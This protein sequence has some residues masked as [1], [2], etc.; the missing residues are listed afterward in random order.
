M[1]ESFKPLLE[2]KDSILFT[3]VGNRLKSDD[4]IGIHICEN[5]V[6]AGRIEILIVEAAIEKFIGKINSINPHTLVLVDCTDFREEPGT[7][8]LLN[9]EDISDTTFHTH[10]ISLRRISEFFKM[11]VYLLGIQPQNVQ[12]GETISPAVLKSAQ[13]ITDWISYHLQS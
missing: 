10:T 3:G 2:E 5:I 12:F 13:I 6:P 8:K 7:F 1:F 9:I 4:A 11:K